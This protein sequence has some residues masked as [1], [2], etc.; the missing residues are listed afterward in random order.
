[1]W[2]ST[3]SSLSSRV[4]I[5]RE[6]F[7]LIASISLGGTFFAR[8][9]SQIWLCLQ[10]ERRQ[11]RDIAAAHSVDV[12]RGRQDDQ[13]QSPQPAVVSPAHVVLSWALQRGVL[14]LPRSSSSKHIDENAVRFLPERRRKVKQQRDGSQYSGELSTT[15][16]TLDTE[17][18]KG[19]IGVFLS[20][21]ELHAIDVLDGT[22]DSHSQCPHW[23][24]LGECEKNPRY[25][26]NSCR[27]SCDVEAAPSSIKIAQ[28]PALLGCGSSTANN[29]GNREGG[30]SGEEL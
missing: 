13:D 22:E 30:S 3:L 19:G 14:V 29:F 7:S 27:V 17:A 6:K 24:G 16:Y 9:A 28:Q 1:M 23:A 4:T 21:A 2:S 12:F 11:P 5:E 15:P 25:M 18:N 8:H 26:L 10:S 20:E